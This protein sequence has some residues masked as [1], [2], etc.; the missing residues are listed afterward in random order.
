MKRFNA[1]AESP[2]SDA[3]HPNLRTAIYRIAVKK[4]PARA[5][6]VLKKEWYNTKSID[7]K[8]ICLGALASVKDESIIQ[9]NLL[10]FCFNKSPPAPASDS[11]PAADMHV[12][13]VNFATND[14][15]RTVQWKYLRDNW[16]ACVSKLGNPIVVDRFIQV[17]LPG[18]TD[19]AVLDEMDAFFADKD[20]KSFDRTLETVKDKI[21][22]RAA[23]RARDSEGLRMWLT[24]NGYM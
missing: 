8:T 20:T 6:E 12:I 18:F 11:V 19:L 13:G 16:D 5:V 17:S 21:R 9:E 10:P 22:G 1:W 24:E 2:G 4:D 3:I 14:V 23:Y 7:G 15:A